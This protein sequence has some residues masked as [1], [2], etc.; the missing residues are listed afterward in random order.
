MKICSQKL[1]IISLKIAF[2]EAMV[3]VGVEEGNY[4]NIVSYLVW[5]CI[6]LLGSKVHKIWQRDYW[7]FI[8]APKYILWVFSAIISVWEFKWVQSRH[9]VAKMILN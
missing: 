1:H 2:N 7:K 4:F 8:F 5:F 3:T 9:F 6:A